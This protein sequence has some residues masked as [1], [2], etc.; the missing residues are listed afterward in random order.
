MVSPDTF[1]YNNET[2]GTNAFQANDIHDKAITQKALIEFNSM[3]NL[4]RSHHI[5]V[6]VLLSRTDRTTPDAVF[7]NNWFSSHITD[8]GRHAVVL[9]PMMAKNRRDERQFKALESLLNKHGITIDEI[10]DLTP[11]E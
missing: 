9:Y 7:P 5:N 1:N 4:L 3:V 8:N 10:I 2:A 11:L 6:Y